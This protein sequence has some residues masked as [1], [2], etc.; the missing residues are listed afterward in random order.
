MEAGGDLKLEDEQRPS[1]LEHCEDGQNTAKSPGEVKDHQL[2]L[3]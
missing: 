1:K 3:V 2:T